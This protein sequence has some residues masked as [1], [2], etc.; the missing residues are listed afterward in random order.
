MKKFDRVTSILIH[1]QTRQVVRARDLA[2]RFGVAERTIYRDI[3]TLENAGVPIGSEAGVGYFLDKAYDLPPVMFS[4][5]EA[6][7]LL[8]GQKIIENRVDAATLDE[9]RQAMDKVRSVLD[10]QDRHYLDSIDNDIAVQQQGETGLTARAD[11]WLRD[12]RT[13]LSRRQPL[14]F[15]YSGRVGQAS[16][17]RQV[18]PVGLYFYSHHWHLIAWCRL[19]EDYRDFRLDR[20]DGLQLLGEQFRRRDFRNLQEYLQR[21]P[22]HEALHEITVRFSD[23]SAQF[24]DEQ[25]Y[26]FGF[27]EERAERNGVSMTFLVPRLEYFARWLLQYTDGVE[28]VSGD[29]LQPII[30]DLLAT[31]ATHWI[32]RPE[33]P[34]AATSHHS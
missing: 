1:L 16:T 14:A 8:I 10:S 20:I 13:A 25:R 27:V 34:S 7:A 32:G 24:V 19:R 3:R 28:I 12:C 30:A 21:E 26:Y 17:T 29:A 23:E 5:D 4:R 33:D 15:D 18:E 11:G 31:L 2:E 22:R 6:A 9:F